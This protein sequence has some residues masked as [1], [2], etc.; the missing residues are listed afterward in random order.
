MAFRYQPDP[1]IAA[2]R[3]PA[4]FERAAREGV[5]LRADAPRDRVPGLPTRHCR[6]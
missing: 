5:D 1:S 3:M 2:V 6:D 4:Y